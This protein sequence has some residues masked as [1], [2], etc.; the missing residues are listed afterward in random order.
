MTKPC[1]IRLSRAK[2]W[3]LQPGAVIVSRP[4]IW[5]NPWEPGDPGLF[6]WPNDHRRGSSCSMWM[7]N[8]I[9]RA[10]AANLFAGW[11]KTGEHPFPFGLTAL[12]RDECGMAMVRRRNE[13]RGQIPSA[14]RGRHL[15]CWCPLDRPCHADVL[16]DVAN[17]R[18]EGAR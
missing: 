18:I 16:L 9:T 15:A 1:R 17:R 2:G 12:G 11:L 13:M 5:G 14:L 8:E 6:H 3:R 4:S 7:A 10:E